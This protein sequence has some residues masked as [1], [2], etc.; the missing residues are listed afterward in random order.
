MLN[1]PKPLAPSVPVAFAAVTLAQ[2]EEQRVDT[3]AVRPPDRLV[4]PEA[5]SSSVRAAMK[6]NAAMATRPEKAIRSL[7]HR[8]GLR[9]RVNAAPE[10]GIRCRADLVFRKA[11]VAVFVDGCFWHRC[12]D[13]GTSP[14]M[15]SSYWQAK[16]DRNV[17]R[18]QRQRASLEAAG[19]TVVR[20]WEHEAPAAAAERVAGTLLC[21]TAGAHPDTALAL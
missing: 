16:L 2:R 13:H 18:D 15:N 11:R 4:A 21:A 10:R 17:A 12:P 6:G 1:D 3:P 8:R 7:L 14:S 9:Y 5:S 20:I 19:W